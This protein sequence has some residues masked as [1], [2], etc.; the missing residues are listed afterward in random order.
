MSQDAETV[1]RAACAQGGFDP[2]EMMPNDGP[3]W[4]YYVPGAQAA[5]LDSQSIY[6]AMF[7]ANAATG[8]GDAS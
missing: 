4:R 7:D 2:D 3:R 5:A 6:R 8:G 1:A